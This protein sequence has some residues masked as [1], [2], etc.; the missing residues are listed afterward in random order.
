[1]VHNSWPTY[2]I[3]VDDH[4]HVG[5]QPTMVPY[6]FPSL[7]PYNHMCGCNTKVSVEINGGNEATCAVGM[8]RHP[9]VAATTITPCG[10][11]LR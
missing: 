8:C 7:P 5:C 1:M 6:A 3:V 9:I 10:C 2:G 4:Y 11:S